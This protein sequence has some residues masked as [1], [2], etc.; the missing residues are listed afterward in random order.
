MRHETFR[1]TLKNFPD[2]RLG[3]I[4]SNSATSMEAY[5]PVK[6]EYFFDRHPTAFSQILNFYRTGKLHSPSDICGPL[7]EEELNF[8]GLD[9][10]TME[11][12]CWSKYTEHR[13]AQESLK[14]FDNPDLNPTE[15]EQLLA[16][17]TSESLSGT[18]RE[19]RLPTFMQRTLKRTKPKCLNNRRWKIFKI[20]IWSLFEDHATTTSRKVCPR[21]LN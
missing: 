11:P 3:W 16:N 4:A 20:K 12:C 2:T 21:Y 17:R 1:A 6:E 15:E 10:K 18:Q 14:V 8:W 5:D 19:S 7:F 9:E 13:D